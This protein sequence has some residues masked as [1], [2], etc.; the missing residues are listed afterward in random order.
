MARPTTH[1]IRKPRQK[2]VTLHMS[3][4]AYLRHAWPA[5]L[6]WSHFPAG[7]KRDAKTG[8]KLKAMGLAAGWPD[9]LF[10]LPNG[11]LAGIELKAA[12]GVLSDAQLTVRDQ[13]VAL[14]CG[15]ATCRSVDEVETTITRWLAAF[16]RQPCA[17]T[18]R[19]AA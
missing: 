3:V 19:R 18:I 12:D 1:P 14:R 16:G 4:A 17:R 8:A 11:K 9:F 2:E 5:D 7:E 10:A 6:P 13:F 15:Y